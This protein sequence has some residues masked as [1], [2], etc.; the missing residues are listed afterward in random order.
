MRMEKLKK[1]LR[2]KEEVVESPWGVETPKTEAY[3]LE[4]YKV[5]LQKMP[6][7]VASRRRFVLGGAILSGILSILCIVGQ[8]SL[9]SIFFIVFG[10]VMV[11]YWRLLGR[12]KVDAS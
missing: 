10:L 6:R 9:V 4:K 2:K 3:P 11:D 8:A 7:A 12:L 5:K 1:L